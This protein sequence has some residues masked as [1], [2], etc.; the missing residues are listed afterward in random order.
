MDEGKKLDLTETIVTE[1]LQNGYT[2]YPKSNSFEKESIS[3][4]Q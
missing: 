3:C 4:F 1:W 2:V